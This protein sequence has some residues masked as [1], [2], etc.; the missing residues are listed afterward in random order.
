MSNGA[1]TLL[2]DPYV[3]VNLVL[4]RVGVAVGVLGMETLSANRPSLL[5]LDRATYAGLAVEA[6]T[7]AVATWPDDAVARAGRPRRC[8]APRRPAPWL[9]P[10]EG[11][12]F[13]RPADPAERRQ[14]AES[15]GSSGSAATAGR[16]A[17]GTRPPSR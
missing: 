2:V 10:T 6:A 14:V 7:G 17:R 1:I 8:P 16:R 9:A 12:T 3:S 11:V 5:G 13:D 4:A 15:P